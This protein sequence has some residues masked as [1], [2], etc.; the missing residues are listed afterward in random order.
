MSG[1]AY[2]S[3]RQESI[4]GEVRH[5]NDMKC[6]KHGSLGRK[7]AACEAERVIKLERRKREKV[8]L[9]EE[10]PIGID[11]IGLREL[12]F[13]ER[14]YVGEVAFAGILTVDD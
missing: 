11:D 6:P 8:P 3:E 13:D 10:V 9:V 1:Y 5:D 2:K 7:D 12:M 14:D 4:R